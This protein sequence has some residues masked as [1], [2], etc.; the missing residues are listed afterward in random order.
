MKKTLL[1]FA[2]AILVSCSSDDESTN[3]KNSSINPPNWIQGKWFQENNGTIDKNT[4]Y[5][6][7][8]NDFCL[9]VFNTET[10]FGVTTN[11]TISAGGFV[12]IEELVNDNEYK[13]SII[14]DNSTLT[15]HF[16]K[17]SATKIEW[18]NDPIGSLD[19][20]YYIKQ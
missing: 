4:G 12:K 3:S 5:T 14:Q 2:I 6:F 16:K 19:E 11:P 15:Y 20:T 9:N 10:C 13:I 1:L 18:L 7:K 8:K 17:I